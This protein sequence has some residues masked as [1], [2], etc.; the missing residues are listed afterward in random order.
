MPTRSYIND[1]KADLF[2]ANTFYVALDNHKEGDYKP[3]LLKTTDKGLTW[4]NMTSNLKAPNLI[5]RLVQ[6][7]VDKNL[8]F[9]GTEFG[10]Y[11]SNDGGGRWTQLKS[12]LPVISFRDLAIQRRE[13]DLVAA[14]FGRS[15]Y[16]LDDYSALRQINE[17][18]L[19]TESKL[20]SVRDAWWYVPRSHLGFYGKRGDQGAGHFVADNP[21]FGAVFSYYLP[22]GLQTKK[23]QRQAAEK[24]K[25]EGNQTVPDWKL[26]DG[27][28]SELKPKIWLM[29]S[30][31]A[32][33]LIR[34][35]EAP[36][37]K[38]FHRVAWDLK[39]PT[40]NV[41]KLTPDPAPEWGGPPSGLMAA[42]GRYTVSM[43]QEENGI[44]T[45]LSE[46]QTFEVKPLRKG[47][48]PGSSMEEVTAFW[49]S[50]EKAVRESSA[51]MLSL[52]TAI[53]T[54]DAMQKA[55]AQSNAPAG[56]LDKEVHEL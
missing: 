27:E 24:E 5:W 6:D 15:I 34:R 19:K 9:I 39:H 30:N 49:R 36:A 10:I 11:F 51:M 16:V 46:P 37:T 23:E 12:G 20:F 17:Q 45:A 28:A 14:S 21:P 43:A 26:L 4:K 47:S 18:Q 54:V 7:H 1:I 13:N 52:N 33:E 56:D 55:I 25:K 35:I 32:G 44:L 50:Y 53:K 22:K 40:P 42:P 8:L 38:G 3:Y 48:L 31:E 41:I 2:D 29:V